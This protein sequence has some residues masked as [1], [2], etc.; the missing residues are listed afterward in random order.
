MLMHLSGSPVVRLL[1][2]SELTDECVVECDSPKE[3]VD[4]RVIMSDSDIDCSEE[5][6]KT[7]QAESPCHS[8]NTPC[9]TLLN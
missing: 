8:S 1:S 3:F 4:K 6:I 9:M 2:S 5:V 7:E